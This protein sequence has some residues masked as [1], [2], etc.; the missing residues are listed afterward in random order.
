[1]K[2]VINAEETEIQVMEEKKKF[3]LHTKS[4]DKEIT[5]ALKEKLGNVLYVPTSDDF[6]V[7]DGKI[8]KKLDSKARIKSEA[9]KILETIDN[10]QKA[11]QSK[12]SQI[13]AHL[14]L[15]S[16]I[17]MEREINDKRDYL[18][19]DN[20]IL[21]IGSKT[22]NLIPHNPKIYNTNMFKISL[23]GDDLDKVNDVHFN[24]LD[25]APILKKYFE[26][27][28]FNAYYE[29]PQE[30]LDLIQEMMGYCLTSH[31]KAQKAFFLWGSGQDGK[32][33]ICDV[34]TGLLGK[35]N[36]SSLTFESFNKEFYNSDLIGKTASI[37][38]ESKRMR[39]KEDANTGVFKAIVAGDRITINIKGKPLVSY[40]PFAKLIFAVNHC[41]EVPDNSHGFARRVLNIPFTRQVPNDEVN[42]NLANDIL[43][44]EFKQVFLFALQ[45]LKRLQD[46]N[47]RFRPSKDIEKATNA[48]LKVIDPIQDFIKNN[49]IVN[50]KAKIR[51]DRLQ[52]L[53]SEYME[54][55]NLSGELNINAI[56]KEIVSKLRKE[57][58]RKERLMINGERHFYYLG[59]GEK[60][61]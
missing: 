21:D 18:I 35:E 6:Y 58:V 28:F 44:K 11:T 26:D 24:P 25:N 3:K 37:S 15:I 56:G 46:R 45:G 10:G 54:L 4:T 12:A 48:Y 47:Y 2:N 22:F 32:S 23:S 41:P 59:I 40:K 20:C 39:F 60:S 13:S 53:Y 7:Y 19:L 29:E 43:E 49:L 8:W 38:A 36:T 51:S 52:D 17:E 50:E 30:T 14:E 34:L 55:N 9:L 1:M 61:S 57:K 31:T 33:V 42:V 5:E 16:L 27:T